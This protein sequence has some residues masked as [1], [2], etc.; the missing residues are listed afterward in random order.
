[1]ILLEIGENEFSGHGGSG[2]RPQGIPEGGFHVF[3]PAENMN[4]AAC[5]RL[6]LHE[7]K[8]VVLG[9]EILELGVVRL[10]LA[11]IPLVFGSGG[12]RVGGLRQVVPGFVEFADAEAKH[13]GRDVGAEA[14]AAAVAGAVITMPDNS[15]GFG[16]IIENPGGGLAGARFPGGRFPR[17]SRA[18]LR[19]VEIPRGGFAAGSPVGEFPQMSGPKDPV[20]PG[21]ETLQFVR[22]IDAHRETP[23]KPGTIW[24]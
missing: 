5:Y 2:R 10:P 18:A 16:L 7:K 11:G 4:P 6:G 17:R 22:G 21:D 15:M 9:V 3:A 24:Q 1:M 8:K 14:A 12:F 23:V 20:C 13:K 19:R